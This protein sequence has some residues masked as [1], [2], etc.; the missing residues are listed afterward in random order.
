LKYGPQAQA[1]LHQSERRDPLSLPTLTQAW[2]AK[3]EP[4][5]HSSNVDLR[6]AGWVDGAGCRH[7]PA[8]EGARVT[9]WLEA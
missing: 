8:G 5:N 2:S 9:P 4:R 7:W 1:G 6:Q 3:S